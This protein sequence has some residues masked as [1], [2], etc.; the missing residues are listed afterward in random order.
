M[1]P[2]PDALR[3]AIALHSMTQRAAARALG[4]CPAHLSRV[5]RRTRGVSPALARR[6]V[7]RFGV[8]SPV[9]WARWTEH[10]GDRARVDRV[11]LDR[12]ARM[13]SLPLSRVRHW[14]ASGDDD[15]VTTLVRGLLS[16]S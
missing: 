1:L 15:A 11:G 2:P 10:Q 5:L 3:R 8:G 4:C 16:C 12:C 9:E 13:L 7:D 14:Y 6:I